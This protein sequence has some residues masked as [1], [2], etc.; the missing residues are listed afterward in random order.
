M[1]GARIYGTDNWDKSDFERVDVTLQRGSTTAIDLRPRYLFEPHPESSDPVLGRKTKIVG[2]ASRDVNYFGAWTDRPNANSFRGISRESLTP[3]SSVEF[4]FE[5]SEVYWRAVRSPAAGKA[6]IFI[7]GILSNTVDCYSPRSTTF[8]QFPYVRTG[9]S[10]TEK[11]LIKVVV[12]GQKHP[13]SAGVAVNHVAFEY[14]AESYK[15][16]AG[17]CSLMGKNNWYYQQWNGS[18]YSDLQFIVDDSHPKL[19]WFGPGTLKVGPDYQIPGS[20][21]AVRTWVAPHGGVIR[22]EG[23]AAI[24]NFGGRGMLASIRQN[25]TVLWPARTI[26]HAHLALHDLTVTV[27]QGDAIYFVA[28][29]EAAARNEPGKLCWD[30]TITYTR[31]MPAVW[32][33]NPPSR[34]NLALNKYARSKTLVSS[35]RPFDGVDG[36]L[37]TAFTIAADDK[38][39]SGDDWFRVDLDKPCVIDHYVVVFGPG[40]PPPGVFSLQS[41]EDGFAWMTVDTATDTSSDRVERDVA[42]FRGRYV[43]L[44]LPRGKPFSVSEFELYHTGNKG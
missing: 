36:N 40:G 30:P 22:I 18:D 43:R 29:N 11:H 39:S 4:K 28:A 34:Q 32:K 20:S 41:S 38:I 24:D 31:T 13:Q 27:E 33:P 42:P 2:A 5:G 23:Q 8:E 26:T 6:D 9:L 3:G 12:R 15:A 10:S 21:A 16:S 35:Y 17:F 44:Y 25:V 7:D 37:Q 19:Y 1:E 14:S